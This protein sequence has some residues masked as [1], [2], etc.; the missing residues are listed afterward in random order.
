METLHQFL[1]SILVAVLIPVA[2]ALGALLGKLIKV[3]ISHIN[4]RILQDVAWQA[5]LWVEQTAKGIE[6]SKKFNKA[7][8]WIARKLP[9]VSA[10][11]AEN[12]IE[13]AVRQMNAQFPK[14]PS[15]QPK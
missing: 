10:D 9:G 12:A 11:E 4:N 5:V 13:A 8:D 15:S 6:G 3:G 1:G 7:L 14:V 2:T